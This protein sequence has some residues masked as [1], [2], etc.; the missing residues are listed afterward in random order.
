MGPSNFPLKY[1][2]LIWSIITIAIV[3]HRFPQTIDE[4]I[5]SIVDLDTKFISVQTMTELRNLFPSK[6]YEE[7][8]HM[9]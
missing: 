6:S 5:K 4:I 3:M 2:L 9:I 1:F 7:E 8:V